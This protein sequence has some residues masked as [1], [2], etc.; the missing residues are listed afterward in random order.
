MVGTTEDGALIIMEVDGIERSDPPQ[1]LTLQ[2]GAF[3]MRSVGA[4]YAINL[5]GGGSSATYY[6]GTIVDFPTCNYKSV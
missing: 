2:Q 1:G 4:Y 5:D 6:N 3:W